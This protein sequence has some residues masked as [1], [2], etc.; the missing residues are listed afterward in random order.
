MRIHSSPCVIWTLVPFRTLQCFPGLL[1]TNSLSFQHIANGSIA[2]S[3]SFLDPHPSLF[4]DALLRKL[5]RPSKTQQT[6]TLMCYQSSFI[7]CLVTL[8]ASC[9]LQHQKTNPKQRT[10][11]KGY[12]R[13]ELAFPTGQESFW[14]CEWREWLA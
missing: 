12:G 9:Y 6:Y 11:A 13:T 5:P 1:R 8:E 3:S 4:R 14:M 10:E 7:S 2:N